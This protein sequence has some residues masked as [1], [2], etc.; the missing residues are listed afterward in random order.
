MA[1]E[2]TTPNVGLQVPAFNQANWQVPTNYNW[3]LLD[4]IFGGEIPVP[5][6]NIGT[7][8]ISNIAALIAPSFV[9]EA[10]AGVIPGNS[11]T[12]SFVPVVLLAIFVNGVYQ[13]PGIDY[14][15]GGS[16]GTLVTL[17]NATTLITDTVSAIYLKGTA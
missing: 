12:L 11:Y 2:T 7:I 1:S 6:I 10:P 4:Q 16:Q 14:T 9:A 13:R 17:S 15:V 3:N 8:V 5:A